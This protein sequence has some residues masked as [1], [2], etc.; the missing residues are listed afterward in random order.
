[1]KRALPLPR[2]GDVTYEG[3]R[4]RQADGNIFFPRGFTQFSPFSLPPCEKICFYYKHIA[5]PQKNWTENIV[6]AA[7]C[8]HFHL[9]FI[10]IAAGLLPEGSQPGPDN[11]ASPFGENADLQSPRG[12]STGF[13]ISTGFVISFACFEAKLPHWGC[14]ITHTKVRITSKVKNPFWQC[15]RCPHNSASHWG[16]N[17][18]IFFDWPT[19]MAVEWLRLRETAKRVYGVQKKTSGWSP[20][21]AFQRQ[22]QNNPQ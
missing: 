16:K 2:W 5:F 4:R 3:H 13:A 11:W 15:P 19:T 17:A 10:L 9:P 20:R 6:V 7:A 1:M 8:K 22:A 12:I 14:V 21:D 18:P